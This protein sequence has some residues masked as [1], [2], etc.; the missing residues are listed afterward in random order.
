[1]TQRRKV[2]LDTETTGLDMKNGDRVIEIGCVEV[3]DFRITGEIF[4]IYLNPEREISKEATRVHGITF[5]QLADS[6]KFIDIADDFLKFIDSS[7]IVAH[8]ASFDIRFL[9]SELI[10]ARQ[11]RLIKLENVIDTLAMARKIFPGSPASLDA[12]C[13]RFRISLEQRELHGALLDA[14]LLARVYIE[15]SKGSQ[16][17]MSFLEGSSVSS[18]KKM[19]KEREKLIIT[20]EESLEHSELIRRLKN[21]LWDEILME[22]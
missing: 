14:Q 6:P 12:L 2:I 20:P 1:M 5:E 15:L 17:S 16:V 4:H 8:N 11:R 9:N 22:E 19:F 3:V 10:R 13:R 21:P 7:E 18:E